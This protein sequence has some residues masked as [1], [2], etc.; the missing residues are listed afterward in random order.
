MKKNDLI[1]LGENFPQYAARFNACAQMMEQ[2]RYYEAVSSVRNILIDQ[3]NK[4]LD[5][6]RA[7][8]IAQDSGILQ[9]MR[10]I[11]LRIEKAEAAAAG[12]NLA[13]IVGGEVVG[14]YRRNRLLKWCLGGLNKVLSWGANVEIPPA[15]IDYVAA[16]ATISSRFIRDKNYRQMVIGYLKIWMWGGE[17]R[18]RVAEVCANIKDKVCGWGRVLM[19]RFRIS[20]GISESTT[21]VEAGA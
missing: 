15:I 10:E 4:A 12:K 18:K 17:K 19:S 13:E 14:A 20:I 11:V 1:K 7:G 8:K 21:K 2:G 6:A 3:R 9:S 5:Y 16:V